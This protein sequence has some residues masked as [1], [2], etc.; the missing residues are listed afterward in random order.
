MPRKSVAALSIVAKT[1][2]DGRP[3]PPPDFT[4]AAEKRLWEKLVTSEPADLFATEATRLL[5][6][7]LVRHST[8]LDYF[9]SQIAAHIGLSQLQEQDRPE[10]VRLLTVKEMDALARMRARETE[11]ALRIARSLRLT[12]QSRWDPLKMGAAGRRQAEANLA[13][14][15]DD[16]RPWQVVA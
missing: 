6:R 12:N 3:K 11:C 13:S 1:A 14:A 4:A 7:D 8:A 16:S 5:L 15:A 9:S 10:G 2:I